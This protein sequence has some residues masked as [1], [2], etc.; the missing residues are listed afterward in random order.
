MGAISPVR[1]LH[2]YACAM[3][4]DLREYGGWW[5]GWQRVATAR[6]DPADR[7]T[8]VTRECAIRKHDESAHEL[9]LNWDSA[10]DDAGQ[11]RRCV[12]CSCSELFQE[13]A[14]PQLTGIVIVLAF[15]GAAAGIF[16][17]VTDT[18]MLIAMAIVLAMD[19]AILVFSKRRLVCYR[20]RSSYHDLP[21]A[22]YHRRWDRT[23]A[24]RYGKGFRRDQSRDAEQGELPARRAAAARSGSFVA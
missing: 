12:V 1:P 21:I 5:V 7:P 15:A 4:I 19:V 13:K 6:L 14:F 3:R 20:C 9:F 24:E 2:V 23:I 8:R 18:P 10:L 11:L 22:R 16:G 17:F